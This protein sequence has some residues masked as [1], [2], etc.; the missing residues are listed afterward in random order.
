MAVTHEMIKIIDRSRIHIQA[1][2]GGHFMF[3]TTKSSQ[4]EEYN[5]V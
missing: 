4:D 2:I 3:N 1:I 5:L